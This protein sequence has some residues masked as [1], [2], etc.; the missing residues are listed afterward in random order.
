MVDA[1]IENSLQ[2]RQDG[3]ETCLLARSITVFLD[4]CVAVGTLW[5]QLVPEDG[6]LYGEIKNKANEDEMETEIDWDD[7]EDIEMMH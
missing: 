4:A 7:N 5:Y 6:P 2:A 3:A 1:R